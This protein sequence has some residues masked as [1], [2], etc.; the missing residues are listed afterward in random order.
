MATNMTENV[1]NGGELKKSIFWEGDGFMELGDFNANSGLE[2][3]RVWDRHVFWLT[4]NAVGT[5]GLWLD[6]TW[7]PAGLSIFGRN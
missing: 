7:D 2:R 3:P 4:D 6:P 5:D 1:N